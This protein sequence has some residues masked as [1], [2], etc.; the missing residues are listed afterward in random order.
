MTFYATIP[1]A[2][3]STLVGQ[4]GA[5]MAGRL[6]RSSPVEPA[7]DGLRTEV[8]ITMPPDHIDYEQYRAYPMDLLA[9]VNYY[10]LPAAVVEGAKLAPVE[11]PA[12]AA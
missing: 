7:P 10:R 4:G 1:T 5:S 2:A 9:D 6:V 3:L 8:A 12:P 11:F